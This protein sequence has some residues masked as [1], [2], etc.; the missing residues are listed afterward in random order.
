MGVAALK[1]H[2]LGMAA[3]FDFPALPAA[4][5][6]KQTG[7]GESCPATFIQPSTEKR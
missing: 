4:E 7:S 3:F 1:G 2:Q 5:A 6:G